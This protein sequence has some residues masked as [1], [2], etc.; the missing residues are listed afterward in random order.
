V[1]IDALA[2]DVLKA[3]ER[4]IANGFMFAGSTLGQA[5]GGSGALYVSHQLGF[6]WSY[7]VVLGALAVILVTVSLRIREPRPGA[8]AV[9]G[10]APSHAETRSGP[11]AANDPRDP[12]AAAVT[13][14]PGDLRAAAR[15]RGFAA[16]LYRGFFRSGKGPLL[17]IA[18]AL[19]P[20][21]AV[22]LG[23]ALGTTLQVDLGMSDKQ[24]ADL[25]LASTIAGAAGCIL[26]GWISDR[27]GHRRTL[28]VFYAL[29][30]P[31]T[32]WLARQLTGEGVAGITL[33]EFYAASIVYSFCSGLLNGTY[34]AIFMGLTSPRVAATQFTAYMAMGNAA[35]AWSS[36]WQGKVAASHGYATVFVIDSLIVLVPILIAPFLTASTRSHEAVAA[37][38][39]AGSRRDR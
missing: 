18:F 34:L 35:Y 24:I 12:G 20:S 25:T 17:G 27:L 7:A 13:S 6:G 15:L 32:L 3:E 38:P 31:P 9:S 4:G 37:P 36:A 28:V 29:T 39:R 23:L 1:A 19:L 33:G 11:P 30:I 22:A 21:G 14:P 2:V 8:S 5:V 10:E 16:E 26:G